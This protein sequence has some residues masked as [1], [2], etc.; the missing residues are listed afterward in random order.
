MR[1]WSDYSVRHSSKSVGPRHDPYQ[2]D[3]WLVTNKRT[4]KAASWLQAS[5]GDD[6]LKF[7]EAGATKPCRVE[8]VCWDSDMSKEQKAMLRLKWELL[9]K[10]WVGVALD[11]AESEYNRTYEADLMGPASRHE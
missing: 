10:R 8:R 4:D 5:L 1:I 9:F 6:L 2:N 3:E 7:F 11:E